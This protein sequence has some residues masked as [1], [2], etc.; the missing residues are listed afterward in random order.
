M[1]GEGAKWLFD[2]AL[3]VFMPKLV[4]KLILLTALAACA[5]RPPPLPGDTL[6]Q[7]EAKW[8][9]P[10]AVYA[11]P[12]GTVLEYA[13][14]PMGQ[15]TWMARL[16]ADGRLL[17]FEQVLTAE[18]FGALKIGSATKADV[19]RAVGRPAEKSYLAIPQLEV[20][21]YRYRESGVW[22][23]MM[24][25]HFNRS[26]MLTMLQNGPDPMYEHHDSGRD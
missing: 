9:K 2:V 16:G 13:T 15:E 3:V 4:P 20:W 6:A 11:A 21:S 1:R 19:L 25:A 18:H 10:T 24:H 14:G 23:S 12:E 26:G 22:N 17:R 8:G 7:V 5:T